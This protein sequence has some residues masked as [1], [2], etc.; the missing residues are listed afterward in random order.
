L[1]TLA[2][3]SEIPFHGYADGSQKQVDASLQGGMVCSVHCVFFLA[4]R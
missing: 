3:W 4:L 1:A 2:R